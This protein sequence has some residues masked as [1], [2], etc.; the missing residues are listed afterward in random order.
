MDLSA[1]YSKVS[2]FDRRLREFELGHHNLMVGLINTHMPQVVDHIH[3]QPPVTCDWITM[4]DHPQQVV[5]WKL[6]DSGW[7]DDERLYLL[8]NGTIIAEQREQRAVVP[9]TIGTW[10]ELNRGGNYHKREVVAIFQALFKPGNIFNTPGGDAIWAQ[11]G[12]FCDAHCPR[13]QSHRY[14]VNDR[15]NGVSLQPA[16][17]QPIMRHAIDNLESF[18][19]KRDGFDETKRN[20]A[21]DIRGVDCRKV[22]SLW[23]LRYGGIIDDQGNRVNVATLPLREAEN[24]AHCLKTLANLYREPKVDYRVDV[25]EPPQQPTK[26]RWFEILDDF[27]GM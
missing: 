6:C 10:E 16:W 2:E 26:R 22:G 9:H 4:N 12:R 21:D 25:P 19:W 24:I 17:L 20:F 18:Y 27:L 7:S 1:H 3:Q 8:P 11:S 14:Y 5:A 13:G 15:Y 23:L